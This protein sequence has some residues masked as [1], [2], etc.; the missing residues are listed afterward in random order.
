MWSSSAPL[1]PPNFQQAVDNA[2]ALLVRILP[3]LGEKI[4]ILQVSVPRLFD[5]ALTYILHN[6][7]NLT[8]LALDVNHLN[9]HILQKYFAGWCLYQFLNCSPFQG[10]LAPVP[11]D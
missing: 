11:A 9:T 7:P 8:N 4:T 1:I 5:E 10:G 2:N 3:A 6:T